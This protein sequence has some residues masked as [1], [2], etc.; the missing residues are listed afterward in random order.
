MRYHANANRLKMLPLA[1]AMFGC[2]Y[3]TLSPSRRQIRST[4]FIF[5]T[6]PAR[7]SKAVI[8]R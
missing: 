7:C 2:L 6:Q 4:R 8:R 3:G 5:T 1:A